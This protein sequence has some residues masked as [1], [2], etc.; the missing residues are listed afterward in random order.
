[1]IHDNV[2][3]AHELM[4]Y[5]QSAKNG[6]NKGFVAKLDMSKA[7]DRVEWDFLEKVLLQMGFAGSWVAKIM[8]CVRTIKYMVKCNSN[9]SNII[10][11]ERGLR[12]GDSLS[13]Y[14]FLFCMNALSRMLLNAQ[15]NGLMRGIRVFQNNPRINHLFFTN[16]SLLFIRNK[17]GDAELVQTILRDFE[18]VSGQKINLSKPSLFFSLNKPREQRQEL[19]SIMGM[20]VMEELEKYLGL[21]LTVGKNKTNAFRFLVDRFSNRI[22]DWSKRLLS[23]G[24]KEIFSKAVLQSLPT[25][26]FSVFLLLKGILEALEDRMR[27]F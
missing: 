6:S 3:I 21:P 22:K 15:N 14:L 9:L 11:L 24:G 25:Y 18:R 1:M 4:H 27:N 26:T 12:Q 2:L 23:Y 20:R 5:L 7:Y 10:I 13:T 19:G 8:D 16:D 17:K